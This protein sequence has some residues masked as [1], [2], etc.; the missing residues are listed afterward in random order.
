LGKDEGEDNKKK[1][2]AVLVNVGEFWGFFVL[3]GFFGV[4]F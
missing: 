4:L 3:R 2:C 1:I